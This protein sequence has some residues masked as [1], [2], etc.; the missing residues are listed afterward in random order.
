MPLTGLKVL[1]IADE[2][3]VYCG[4]LFAD[5]GAEVLKIEPPGGDATRSF[6]PFVNNTQN[7][8]FFLY[9]NTSKKSIEADIHSVEGQELI[10]QLAKDAYIVI[11]TLPP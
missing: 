3:G 5:L 1:E 4:K 8:L 10:R 7:S 9:M 2:R 11:E 6:A